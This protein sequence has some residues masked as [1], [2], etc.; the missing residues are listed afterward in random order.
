METAVLE[1]SS[2]L[3]ITKIGRVDREHVPET[4]KAAAFPL[5]IYD[6]KERKINTRHHCT[7]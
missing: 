6:E 7:R 5:S 1:S 3:W 4:D 2:L